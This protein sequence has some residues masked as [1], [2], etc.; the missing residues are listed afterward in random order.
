MRLPPSEVRIW[1]TQ[2][3]HGIF[4][5]LKKSERNFG[6]HSMRVVKVKFV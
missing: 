6:L 1:L 5:C 2:A 4:L 3:Y